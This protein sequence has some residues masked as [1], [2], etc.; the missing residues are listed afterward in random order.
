MFFARHK[1]IHEPFHAP[2][3]VRSMVFHHSPNKSYEEFQVRHIR[4]EG[5]L[6]DGFI[7]QISF[8]DFGKTDG[9]QMDKT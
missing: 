2:P 9:Q 5:K 3:S 1:L 6:F 8:S 4:E 7:G